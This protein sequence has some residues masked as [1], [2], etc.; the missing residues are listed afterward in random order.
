MTMMALDL[1]QQQHPDNDNW[2]VSIKLLPYLFGY[3]MGFSPL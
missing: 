2:H 3:K 1:Y